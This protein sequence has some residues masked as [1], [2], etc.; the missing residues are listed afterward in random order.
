MQRQLRN[1]AYDY[2]QIEALFS[3]FSL[4][5]VSIPLPSMRSWE[6]SPDCAAVLVSVIREN[7]P[8]VIVEF[9]S[10]VS[11][12]IAG[13][14]AK[15]NKSGKIISFVDDQKYAEISM[16]NIK[17]HHLDSVATIIHAPQKEIALKEKKYQW[18][19]QDII[20]SVLENSEPID[21]LIING[22]RE[23]Q[24]IERYPTL[25]VL[26]GFLANNAVIVFDDSINDEV[27]KKT[28]SSWMQEFIDMEYEFFDTEKGTFVLRK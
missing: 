11:T 14:A 9:G 16:D 18:Y 10:G 4:L 24:N 23:M 2:K 13:Y 12:I 8:N 3:L 25:P 27:E 28:I 21:L 19:D 6:I 22:L 7:K 26:F 15:E 1:N 20:L 5:K 17:A